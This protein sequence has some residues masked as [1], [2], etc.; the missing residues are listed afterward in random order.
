MKSSTITLIL[1]LF[2]TS[3]YSQECSIE[4][5]HAEIASDCYDDGTF[6]LDLEFDI[7]NGNNSGF[8]VFVNDVFFKYFPEYPNPFVRLEN[9]FRGNGSELL[10]SVQDNDNP[11]CT[12]HTFLALPDCPGACSLDNLTVEF[13]ECNLFTGNY[14]AMVNWTHDYDNFTQFTIH[15]NDTYYG[16]WNTGMDLPI[17]FGFLGSNNPNSFDVLKVC[18]N[19]SQDCCIEYQYPS[20]DCTTTECI[21]GELFLEERTACDA[22][23]QYYIYPGF[24][25]VNLS[26]NVTISINGEDQGVFSTEQFGYEIGPFNG[27]GEY[28]QITICDAQNPECCKTDTIQSAYCEPLDECQINHLVVEKDCLGDG[29]FNL[30]V[31]FD[32]AFTSETVSIFINSDDFGQFEVYEQPIILGPIQEDVFIN[33]ISVIDIADEECNAIIDVD[34]IPCSVDSCLI[35]IANAAKFCDGAND[36]ISLE[37]IHQTANP[38]SNTSFYVNGEYITSNNEFNNFVSI[39]LSDLPSPTDNTYT[40][41]I[42]D[43][44]DNSCQDEITICGVLGCDF[45]CTITELTVE[46]ECLSNGSFFLEVSATSFFGIEEV[47]ITGNGTNYGTFDF[48]EQPFILGPFEA[49][50]FV[51]ELTLTNAANEICQACIQFEPFHC[52]TEPCSI[53]NIQYEQECIDGSYYFNITYDHSLTSGVVSL[54]GNGNAYGDFSTEEQPIILGPFNPS[55]SINELVIIDNLNPNCSSDTELFFHSC[56]ECHINI[57]SASKYCDGA[58]DFIVLDYIHES[59]AQGSSTLFYVNDVLVGSNNET[60]NEI[61]ITLSDLPNTLANT[62]TVT[63]VDEANPSCQD[64]ITICGVAGC[65][66]NCT[67]EELYYETE[68]LP[69]GTYYLNVFASNAFGIDQVIL[70][71]NGQVYGTFDFAD[72]PFH[73]GPFTADDLVTEITITALNNELCQSCIQFDQIECDFTEC[74]LDGLEVYNLTCDSLD[75]S[76]SMNIDFEHV[77]AGPTYSVFVNGIRHGS[78][79]FSNGSSLSLGGI[80]PRANSDYDIIQ[81]CANNIEDCCTVLEYLP[82]SCGP[83]ACYLDIHNAEVICDG[84]VVY[85]EM[86]YTYLNPFSEAHFYVNGEL[87]EQSNAT[88]QQLGIQLGPIPINPDGVYEIAVFDAEQEG[89]HAILTLNNSCGQDCF[90]GEIL[91]DQECLND[92]LYNIYLSFEFGWNTTSVQIIGNGQDYGIFD[93]FNQPIELGTFTNDN[94]INEFIIIDIHNP[95][96]RNEVIFEPTE[97]DELHGECNLRDLEIINLVC[98]YDNRTYSIEGNFIFNN[99]NNDYYEIFVNDELR[100]YLPFAEGGHFIVEGISSNPNTQIDIIK[101]CVNDN[102]D[103][104]VEYEFTPPNCDIDMGDCLVNVWGYYVICDGPVSYLD[105]NYAYLNPFSEAHFYVNGNFISASSQTGEELSI[106]LG[107]IPSTP[108]DIYIVEIFDAE[109]DACYTVIDIL[110]D[111]LTDCNLSNLTVDV[112]DCNESTG[113]YSMEVNFN[114]QNVHSGQFDVWVN[115]EFHDQYSFT[116]HPPFVVENVNPRPNSDFDIIR[117]C[118]TD[119]IEC[120]TVLEYLQP[121]CEQN[122]A[123][124]IDILEYNV[125]CDGPVTYIE[126]QYAY[127]NPFS[128]AHFAVNGDYVT[129]SS[130]TGDLLS[131][132]LGP[133]P[134][135]S[136][137]FLF[138]EAYD[139]ELDACYDA[140]EFVN[141]CS[142]ECHIGEIMVEQDCQADGT[143]FLYVYFDYFNISGTVTVRGNGQLYG[144]YATDQLQIILGPFTNED[145]VNELVIF[146]TENENCRSVAAF[147]LEDCEEN[148]NCALSD[149]TIDVL[150]C[151]EATGVYS[152][153][154]NFNHINVG[155]DQFDVWVNNEFYDQYSFENQPPFVVESISP[156]PNSDYDIIRIC[157]TDSI[158]CCTVLEYI[159]PDCNETDECQINE[160]VVNHECLDDNMYF[161]YV[162]FDFLN[163]SE[164]VTIAGNGTSYGEFNIFEQPIELGPFEPGEI[165]NEFVIQDVHLDCFGLVEFETITCDEEPC[166]IRDIAVEAYDCD[167]STGTYQMDVEFIYE[168]PGNDYFEVWINNDYKGFYLFSDHPPISFE[169]ISPRPNS[170]YDI[171]KICV[172]DD[173]DCCMEYEY[174]APECEEEGPCEIGVPDVNVECLPDGTFYAYLTASYAN[175]S[176]FVIITTNG[177]VHGEFNIENQPFKIGPLPGDG[178]TIYEFEVVDAFHEDCGNSVEIGIVDCEKEEDCALFDV[179]IFV[180]DCDEATNTYDAIVNFSYINPTNNLYDVWVNNEYYDF[181]SFD[182][183]PP[184]EIKDIKPRENSDYEHIKICMNDNE[185][186]CIEFEFLRPT[187][188]ETANTDNDARITNVTIETLDCNDA[189]STYSI[190]IDFDTENY[191]GT[192][193]RLWV[194]DVQMPN[195]SMA[196]LPAIYT[197]ISPLP[198]TTIDH[199]KI[200]IGDQ[201]EVCV[202]ME[203]DQPDC[204]FTGIA[205]LE[206]F[207][208]I[209]LYPNPTDGII[210]LDQLP[211]NTSS[212][213]IFDNLG[214]QRVRLIQNMEL[215]NVSNL[216]KGIYFV[217]VVT[218]ENHYHTLKFIKN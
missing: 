147:D 18:S 87:Y 119:S 125:I 115:N 205:V 138:V 160:I 214:R 22:A 104:C 33:S 156:R 70:T 98:D 140:I 109:D 161:L 5:L 26:E 55:D 126:I 155:S 100:E 58:N 121:D 162:S 207:K 208:Q 13:I 92:S 82:P 172:N 91:V 194:N 97:C 54:F 209:K 19:N 159:Q 212:I 136:G 10:L 216:E 31:A 30:H 146:D 169:G 213:E 173:P 192:N 148:H 171:I 17:P 75:M 21:I 128:E 111:C 174:M 178:T 1:L 7:T 61:T 74:T 163:T 35:Q 16:T 132:T 101:I 68:C 44:S 39:S 15:F 183:G 25:S 42:L 112:I 88:G 106:S 53:S 81:V 59:F 85:I 150:G 94:L 135:V 52:D 8:D 170:D 83:D 184:F 133:I 76:Y 3:L 165:I 2:V 47:V 187:C 51:N 120:C 103:C 99:P 152:M 158:E 157:V 217:K 198:N 102:P 69:D 122:G 108:G 95:D 45:N 189:N 180:S 37:Y 116:D 197:G 118:S 167:P 90:I 151:D 127:L 131:I 57:I 50:T 43:D 40:V 84:P 196:E 34:F 46:K 20:P 175:V 24:T 23:G 105:I 202:D 195:I 32:H 27:N 182:D 29:T 80:I 67:I 71:G 176:N 201:D 65:D 11:D 143:Y 177:V 186:C 206:E 56:E 72:Q 89:C 191:S 12:A 139:A 130:E 200:C 63:V 144:T 48:I 28:Y 14:T 188:L 179:D 38:N 62:Y 79:S 166:D 215:I 154:V 123:C 211:I 137:E 107:P 218:K 141:D 110:D 66:F 204:L 77:N 78:Y 142:E 153:V 193:F 203:Y 185:D 64:V 164:F 6:D 41:V 190:N 49:G 60:N 93:A 4:N 73:L 181:F 129:S 149:L 86:A 9:V 134:T 145:V 124:F 36:F 113:V 199:I 96:C 210:N 117:I 168:N 114:H